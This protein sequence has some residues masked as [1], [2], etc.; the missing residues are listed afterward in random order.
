MYLNG[1]SDIS[2]KI[3]DVLEKDVDQG[4]YAI[5]S[6]T[7]SFFSLPLWNFESNNAENEGRRSGERRG[8]GYCRRGEGRR[9]GRHR[10]HGEQD[11]VG[12]QVG[13]WERRRGLEEAK[14]R[15][16]YDYVS[17]VRYSQKYSVN[18]MTF[19]RHWRQGHRT[20][21]SQESAI[22]E[23]YTTKELHSQISHSPEVMSQANP[24]VCPRQH[25]FLT[26]LNLG[27]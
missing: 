19:Q 2:F 18:I 27:L 26:T 4:R 6:R 23:S 25:F 20:R 24:S 3:L 12:L 14:H 17:A 1:T 8:S 15:S 5:I 21:S 9:R 10:R 13:R 7:L 22:S 16:R 11:L